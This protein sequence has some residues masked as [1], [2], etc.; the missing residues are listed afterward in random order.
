MFDSGNASGSGTMMGSS[1]PAK[2]P[3]PMN[4]SYINKNR[5]LDANEAASQMQITMSS[6]NDCL[7]SIHNNGDKTSYTAFGRERAHIRNKMMRNGSNIGIS[8]GPVTITPG[9]T[10]RDAVTADYNARRGSFAHPSSIGG[11]R[12]VTASLELRA[13]QDRVNNFVGQKRQSTGR[14][15]NNPASMHNFSMQHR[16]RSVNK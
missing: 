6:Q 9:E 10:G 16:Q 11:N 13:Q 3:S 14:S 1:F 7:P 8:A 5:T 4:H 2:A 12:V 15:D